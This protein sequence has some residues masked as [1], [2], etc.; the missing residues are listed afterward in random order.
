MKKD[1]QPSDEPSSTV[2]IMIRQMQPTN[3]RDSS[4]PENSSAI[5]TLGASTTGGVAVTLL[6]Q[7]GRIFCRHYHTSRGRIANW[8]AGSVPKYLHDVPAMGGTHAHNAS[9][10]YEYDAPQARRFRAV[11]FQ[12]NGNDAFTFARR[13]RHDERRGCEPGLRPDA[14]TVDP[15]L[16]TTDD[17]LQD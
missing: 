5:P 16:A 2:L 14:L 12:Q 17:A 8:K 4:T 11:A 15:D 3:S 1:R 6:A 10:L 7:W 9:F 13:H